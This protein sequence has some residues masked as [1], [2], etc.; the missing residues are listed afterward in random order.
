MK[1]RRNDRNVT[2]I[3]AHGGIVKHELSAAA[4]AV[5]Q[6]PAFMGMTVHGEG[7]QVFADVNYIIHPE[8]LFKITPIF[9]RVI[10]LI[11]D[12]TLNTNIWSTI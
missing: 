8:P 4:G 10:D 5:N 2:G 11:K 12:C 7:Y 9:N 1:P 3:I 6:F